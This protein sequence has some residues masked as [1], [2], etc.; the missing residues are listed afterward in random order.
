M[1]GQI[2]K[3]LLE[4]TDVEVPPGL[5]QRQ[6]DRLVMR[7]MVD[8]YQQGLPEQA[9]QKNLDELRARAG[10]DAV[11]EL[12]LFFIMEKIAEQMEIDVGDDE[13]NGEIARIARQQGKR[14]DRVRDELAKGDG[15]RAL[16]LQL[17][18]D[19]ILDELLLKAVVTEVERP[20]KE[21]RKTSTKKKATKKSDD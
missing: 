18:D 7:R 20:K 4:N 1:R 14:F 12:K 13:L 19:K 9:V 10:E 8:M 17:R 6:T 5:T 16:Y 15:L 3:Y 21:A 11:S 2:G